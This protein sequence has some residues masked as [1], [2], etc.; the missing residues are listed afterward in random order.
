[1]NSSKGDPRQKGNLACGH[2]GGLPLTIFIRHYYYNSVLL[3]F[4]VT[5]RN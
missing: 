4:T 1:M 5:S 3:L 2:S